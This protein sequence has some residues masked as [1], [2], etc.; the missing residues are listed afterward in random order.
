MFRKI[1]LI[2]NLYKH[3]SNFNQYDKQEQIQENKGRNAQ[4]GC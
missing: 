3:N 2:K 4:A 1:Q